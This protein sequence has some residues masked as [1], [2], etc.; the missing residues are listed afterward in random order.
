MVANKPNQEQR[1]SEARD[2]DLVTGR[3]QDER[4][5]AGL[6]ESQNRVYLTGRFDWSK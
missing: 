3:Q 6:G 5:K 2:G 1:R 4:R